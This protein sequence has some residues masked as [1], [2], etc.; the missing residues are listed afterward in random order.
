MRPSS[1]GRSASAAGSTP[2]AIQSSARTRSASGGTRSLATTT[3]SIM[4]AS[5][6]TQG[7]PRSR[8]ATP[9]LPRPAGGSSDRPR[10]VAA[11]SGSPGPT[12]WRRRA[13]RVSVRAAAAKST[14]LA[15]CMTPLMTKGC[16]TS[17][18]RGPDATRID[19][20]RVPEHGVGTVA[21]GDRH[22]A[23][24]RI[25][26]A[27]TAHARG[28]APHPE[29]VVFDAELVA[30]L[31]HDIVTAFEAFGERLGEETLFVSK[32]ALTQRARMRGAAPPSRSVRVV[33]RA[34]ERAGRPPRDPADGALAGRGG[35]GGR[36]RRRD[37]PAVRRRHA[38]SATGSPG[39]PPPTRPIC[40]DW[41]SSG[42][43]SSASA[44]PRS[45]SGQLR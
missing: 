41:R 43:R 26:T 20:R 28:A 14:V 19:P 7:R 8:T 36:R 6:A 38:R 40:A 42:S 12:S 37:G 32:H 44:S 24:R 21:D 31:E 9:R 34:G 39:S 4:S 16:R 30:E 3:P 45:T 17:S 10:R 29:P 18:S 33:A 27:A 23:A 15:G 11:G 2:T 5:T 22:R 35:A 25:D 1:A 13:S